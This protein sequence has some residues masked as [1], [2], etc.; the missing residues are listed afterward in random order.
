VIWGSKKFDAENVKLAYLF[1]LFNIG[2][3]LISSIGTVYRKMAVAQGKGEKLYFFW[4]IAQLL[5]AVFT[6]VLIGKFNIM[7]LFFIILINVFFMGVTSY[8]VY[9]KT[10]N[11]I[12]YNFF[13]WNVLFGLCLI[14]LAI[15]FKYALIYFGIIENRETLLVVLI[16]SAL[17][18]SLRPIF[19]TYK[20]LKE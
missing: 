16:L 1:L 6:Y 12:R 10:K 7:G 17:V 18:L 11:A 19:L 3:V 20:L 15:L 8:V 9:K 4:V 2:S 13:N 14:V 5:S